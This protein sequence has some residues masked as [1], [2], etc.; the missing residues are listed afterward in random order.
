MSKDHLFVICLSKDIKSNVHVLLHAIN[1]NQKIML[2]TNFWDDDS[3]ELWEI[4][5]ATE[6]FCK[7]LTTAAL[8]ID[9]DVNNL[10]HSVGIVCNSFD[11]ETK[12]L[13]REMLWLRR[14]EKSKSKPTPPWCH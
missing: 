3:R 2:Y 6:L 7:T 8:T 1:N 10:E 14:A 4:P 13:F 11:E 9:K 5:E 12:E